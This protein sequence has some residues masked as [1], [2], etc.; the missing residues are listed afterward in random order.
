MRL[1]AA[2]PGLA[3]WYMLSGELMAAREVYRPGLGV[4]IAGNGELLDAATAMANQIIECSP[5]SAQ[6]T[7]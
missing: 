5:M 6:H 4:K 1:P 7:K 3:R 2:I